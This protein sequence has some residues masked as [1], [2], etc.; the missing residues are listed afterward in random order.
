MKGYLS[1]WL[2]KNAI[3]Q[4]GPMALNGLLVPRQAMAIACAVLGLLY[5]VEAVLFFIAI[6]INVIR[7][8]DW[9]LL[10]DY[11]IDTGFDLLV[12]IVLIVGAARIAEFV[13]WLRS[14]GV[15][16]TATKRDNA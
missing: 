11:S 3:K 8:P 14:A 2:S 10:V 1:P 5:V 16:A 6:I 7:D 12:G 4:D 15:S 13:V 9:G